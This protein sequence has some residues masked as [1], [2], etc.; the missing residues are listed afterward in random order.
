MRTLLSVLALCS[1]LFLFTCGDG[2][3]NTGGNRSGNATERPVGLTL[4]TWRYLPQDEVIVKDFE[5]RYRIK[6]EVIVKSMHDIVTAAQQGNVPRA[7]VLLV[8][9]IED[10]ARLRGFNVLQPFFVDAFT[11]GQVGDRYL[12]N[13]GYYAGLT[14][15][16]MAAVYNPKAVTGAE[17]SSYVGI[18]KA[19]GRGA[20]IGVA[21][22]D[23][24]G[25]AGLVGGLSIN[26]NQNA[27]AFWANTIYT[28]AA[29]GL[30]GSDND[31]LN[32]MLAGEIDMALVSSGAAT[33]WILNGDPR[34]Y[35][36]GR[37]WRIALPHTEATDINFYNMTCVTMPA[38]AP[39]RNL[40]IA[41]INGL[42]QKKTQ[43]L[44][45]DA[46]FEFPTFAFGRPNDYL[47]NYL[48]TIGTQ[49]G[50]EQIEN[51]TPVGWALINQAAEGSRQ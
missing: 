27:A 48:G 45:T 19:A 32:R 22:P 3:S 38:N 29:G 2:G 43:Q 40:A 18:A 6:V 13:E 7:D 50:A 35:D 36:A 28:K 49:V 34:H 46:W 51:A 31:Q 26:L 39:N 20:R 24:S 47:G 12:D 25:L 11:E 1:V 44:L 14:K 10:A 21:H 16:S 30:Q 5:D 42:F 15:W 37:L 4:M 33:R 17:A 8:P 41:F 23:S 9:T